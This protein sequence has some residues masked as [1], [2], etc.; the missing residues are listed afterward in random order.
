[1]MIMLM[2]LKILLRYQLGLKT[3]VP[4]RVMEMMGRT[5]M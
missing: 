2:I 4:K 5:W 1:M 3:T